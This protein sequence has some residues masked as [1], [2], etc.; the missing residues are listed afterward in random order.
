MFSSCKIP[1]AKSLR[2]RIKTA[3]GRKDLWN[4]SVVRKHF[5]VISVSLKT[6][7]SSLT[8]FWCWFG[9]LRAVSSKECIN[10]R[11]RKSHFSTTASAITMW[12]GFPLALMID[13]QILSNNQSA[14]PNK[15]RHPFEKWRTTE[16]ALLLRWEKFIQLV[17]FLRPLFIGIYLIKTPRRLQYFHFCFHFRT[18]ARK[19]WKMASNDWKEVS[20]CQFLVCLQ[21]ITI[22]CYVKH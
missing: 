10:F 13:L 3:A 18:Y 11:D 8:T 22:S 19:T 12:Y 9:H 16:K 15:R 20:S 2:S 21:P 1:L 4:A 6:W 7:R 14:T 5:K 17:V